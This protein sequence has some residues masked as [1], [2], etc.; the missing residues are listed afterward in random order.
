MVK[1]LEW[2]ISPPT[3]RVLA[4][5]ARA[6]FKGYGD[7]DLLWDRMGMEGGTEEQRKQFG[8]WLDKKGIPALKELLKKECVGSS[9]DRS[10][11]IQ[12]DGWFITANPR[13]SCGYLYIGAFPCDN[14]DPNYM[15]E[16]VDLSPPP[17]SQPKKKRRS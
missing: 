17:K 2:G 8:A 9:E 16:P 15:P 1:D 4:W 14:G 12:L 6:I 7:F 5:G 10:V 3:E 13:M 11:S